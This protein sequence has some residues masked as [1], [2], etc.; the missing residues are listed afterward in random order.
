MATSLK[1]VVDNTAPAY[2]ILCD[3]PDGS[4]IDLTNT[5]VTLKLFRGST[6]TNTTSGHNA[7][8]NLSPATAGIIS[9][10]PKTG[11]LPTAGTYKGD[12]TVT[13]ADSTE[14]TLY[15]N[16]ILKIRKLLG[17]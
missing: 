11:D 4:V 1:A 15:G 16:L 13:Y 8:I 17:S 12:I 3:R 6:Q 14:E 2:N 7:C 10:Q 5:T 9:W